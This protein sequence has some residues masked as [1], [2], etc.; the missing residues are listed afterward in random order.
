MFGK[1]LLIA[2]AVFFLLYGLFA[3]TT[4]KVVWGETLIGF[5]ALVAGIICTI[6]AFTGRPTA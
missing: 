4:I 2:F 6:A 5:A 3:V 1:I